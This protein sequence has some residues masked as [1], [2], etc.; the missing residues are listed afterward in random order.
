MISSHYRNLIT[1]L[2][3]DALR[4]LDQSGQVSTIAV[5]LDF[6]KVALLPL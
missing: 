4:R 5:R 3:F 1:S 6:L 2:Q